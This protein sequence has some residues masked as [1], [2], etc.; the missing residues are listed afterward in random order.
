[1]V[2]NE[3]NL[4]TIEGQYVAATVGP[5]LSGALSEI[6]ERRPFD[7][8]EYLAN[9]LYKYSENK[10]NERKEAELNALIEKLRIEEEINRQ[11]QEEMRKELEA[12]QLAEEN[13]RKEKEAEERAKK[14][15]EEL[16]KRKQE[17]AN[18]PPPLPAVK[19]EDEYL[20]VEF[21]ETKLHAAAAV[22]GSNL[23]E[24]IKTANINL[25]SRNSQYLNARDIAE[26]AEIAE[27][28]KQLD[29]YV[30]DLI[31]SEDYKAVQ[32][33]VINGYNNIVEIVEANL[34]NAEQL[35]AKDMS[36]QAV[37]VF[38]TIPELMEKIHKVK[39]SIAAND[40][41]TL[42]ASLDRKSLAFFRDNHG[43]SA[44]HLAIEKLNLHIA[45]FLLEKYPVLS[46]MND[47][48][49]K[50][51]VDYL[52]ALDKKVLNEEQ[53]PHYEE[54]MNILKA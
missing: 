12:I 14:E 25:A 54:L 34:G 53:R 9:Y 45:L 23:V 24:L 28:V 2:K 33:L 1:M 52:E 15:A 30:C 44:M 7:P 46:K 50:H 41:A 48:H 6:V 20:I 47:C 37:E 39:E 26:K 4:S 13:F 40:L 18:M 32:D 51:P 36:S 22:R 35:E 29:D 3:P 49:G 31:V 43:K 17:L 10:K 16:A 27:N 38:Q 5:A 42:K 21:G 19:E 11:K 8:I